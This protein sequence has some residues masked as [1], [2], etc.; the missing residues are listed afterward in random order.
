[1]PSIEKDRIE[2]AARHTDHRAGKYLVRAAHRR[3]AED[4]PKILGHIDRRAFTRLRRIEH[5]VRGDKNIVQLAGARACG[6]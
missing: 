6:D 3:H 2:R 1:M 5:P 4:R